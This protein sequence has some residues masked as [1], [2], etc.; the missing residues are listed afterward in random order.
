[1]KKLDI[2]LIILVAF[3]S[4]ILFVFLQGKISN[5]YI[6]LIILTFG[7]GVGFIIRQFEKQKNRNS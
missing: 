1:M 3:I 4:A 5:G 7:L 2:L 6:S